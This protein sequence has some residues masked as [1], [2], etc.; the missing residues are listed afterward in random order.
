M[1]L[2]LAGRLNKAANSLLRLLRGWP[3]IMRFDDGQ[4]LPINSAKWACIPMNREPVG[5]ETMAQDILWPGR[6]VELK[7]A[8]C[9]T[10]RSVALNISR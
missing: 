8:S 9:L 2:V 10:A 1:I 7:P 4:L 3:T 5:T 6:P